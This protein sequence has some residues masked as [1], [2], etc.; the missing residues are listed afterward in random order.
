MAEW[1]EGT[2]ITC[3][4]AGGFESTGLT[5]YCLQAREVVMSYDEGRTELLV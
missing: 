4:L 5:A 3:E 1:Q 2:R